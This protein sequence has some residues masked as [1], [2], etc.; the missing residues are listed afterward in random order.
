[1]ALVTTFRGLLVGNNPT[2]KAATMTPA[3]CQRWA[4]DFDK[5]IRL[6]GRD[7]PTIEAVMRWAQADTFWRANILSP[8]KLRAKWDTLWLQM[9]RPMEGKRNGTTRG[10]TPTDTHPPGGYTWDEFN[11]KYPGEHIQQP[12][13][14]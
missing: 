14:S 10:R 7:P 6:D 13:L 1:M 8:A 2:T 3:A 4:S 5:L 12:G 9:Q 11:A